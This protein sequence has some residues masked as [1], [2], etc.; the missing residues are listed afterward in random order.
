MR[1]PPVSPLTTDLAAARAQDWRIEVVD[2]RT[3]RLTHPCHAPLIVDGTRTGEHTRRKLRQAMA[4]IR[5]AIKA[6]SLMCPEGADVMMTVLEL[7]CAS[8]GRLFGARRRD[9]RTCSTICAQRLRRGSRAAAPSEAD[10][11]RRAETQSDAH[12]AG[13]LYGSQ[14]PR[15]GPKPE[16]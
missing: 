5:E 7:L 9:A 14:R 11:L 16:P 2:K 4:E 3:V 13:L 15:A 8:S 6:R 1:K 12:Q 10:Q